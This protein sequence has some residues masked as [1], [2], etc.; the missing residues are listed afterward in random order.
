M[1]EGYAVDEAHAPLEMVFLKILLHFVRIVRAPA[2]G[3][4]AY[5]GVNALQG[6]GQ[7]QQV[8]AALDAANIQYVPT[9]QM[10]EF[11]NDVFLFVTDNLAELR[12][13]ALVNHVNL[14]GADG[15]AVNDFLFRKLADGNDAV[16]IVAGTTELVVID[17][18]VNGLV[19]FGKAQEKQV[20][21]GDD[22]FYTLCL[23]DIQG[24]FV[25][26]SVEDLDAVFL[27]PPRDAVGAPEC[28]SH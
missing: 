14:V 18:A 13:A 6:F 26:Q 9:G 11:A 2:N 20:V 22:G 16:G 3:N 7:Q 28:P 12:V 21:Y 4:D 25:G 8:L 5:R 17:F 27:Q 24:Q 10:V 1:S 23:A 19:S 15:I